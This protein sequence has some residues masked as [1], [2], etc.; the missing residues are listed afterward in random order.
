MCMDKLCPPDALASNW[1]I[2]SDQSMTTACPERKPSSQ[3]KS[4]HACN[5]LTWLYRNLLVC[6]WHFVMDT[7]SGAQ[8][9]VSNLRDARLILTTPIDN[10]Q[11]TPRQSKG[12]ALLCSALIQ[13]FDQTRHR[14]CNNWH[15]LLAAHGLVPCVMVRILT[16]LCS[17]YVDDIGLTDHAKCSSSSSYAAKIVLEA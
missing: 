13:I 4:N 9:G 10:L 14:F 11:S 5:T 6:I 16:L 8:T 12:H 3:W 17:V 2:N 15:C 1:A 7:L